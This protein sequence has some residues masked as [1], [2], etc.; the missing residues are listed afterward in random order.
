MRQRPS[1]TLAVFICALLFGFISATY[2]AEE[3]AEKTPEAVTTVD[4]DIP[5]EEL[6]LLLRPLT[7]DELR[8][9]VVRMAEENRDWGYTRIR[10]ALA[11]LGHE[12][13]RGTI[14]EILK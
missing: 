12:V 10:G 5:V 9:L 11:N 13:G 7:K 8:S 4:P 6:S 14:T 3:G 1:A 2:A